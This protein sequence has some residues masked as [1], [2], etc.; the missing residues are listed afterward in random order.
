MKLKSL[1][2]TENESMKLVIWK[3]ISLI[4]WGRRYFQL[5]FQI[6]FNFPTS[7]KLSNFARFFPTSN[8]STPHSFELNF[9]V[10]R[11]PFRLDKENFSNELIL[12]HSFIITVW[13][14]LIWKNLTVSVNGLGITIGIIVFWHIHMSINSITVDFT[15]IKWQSGYFRSSRSQLYKC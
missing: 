8:F 5:M 6:H 9:P 7:A 2:L 14:K 4:F 3:E 13:V 12:W 10:T 15:V 11:I 1:K